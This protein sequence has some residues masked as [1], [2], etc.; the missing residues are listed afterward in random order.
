MDPETGEL[1]LRAELPIVAL[2]SASARADFHRP[3]HSNWWG[4]RP[5]SGISMPHLTAAGVDR[6]MSGQDQPLW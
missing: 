6:G 3:L 5:R 4:G 1:S 2:S